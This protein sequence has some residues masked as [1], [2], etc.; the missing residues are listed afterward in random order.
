MKAKQLQQHRG[1]ATWVIV[2]D[3]G[4]EAVTALTAFAQDHELTTAHFAAIDAFSAATLGYF[5]RDRKEYKKIPVHEQVEVLSLLG[6]IALDKGRP[7]VHAH[8][9]LGTSDGA[10]RGGHLLEGTVWPT[11][12]IVLQMS[13]GS[14]RKRLERE[15][16]LALIDLD[17]A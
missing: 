12:E 6:D 1:E 5:D 15:V 10:A 7:V 3:K 8:T 4:D 17:A 9:V 13:P 16:G 11:L 14:L 2:L